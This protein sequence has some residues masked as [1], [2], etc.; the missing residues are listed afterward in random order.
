MF[1]FTFACSSGVTLNEVPPLHIHESVDLKANIIDVSKCHSVTW[2]KHNQDID[3][4]HPKYEIFFY[5]SGSAVF[6]INNVKKDDAGIYTIEVQNK[7]GKR[8][9]TRKLEVMGGTCTLYS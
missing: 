8:Q 9:S 2:I 1:F 7:Y 6:R 4:P 5:P 3:S